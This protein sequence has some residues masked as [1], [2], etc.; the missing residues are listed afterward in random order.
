MV[1]S[2]DEFSTRQVSDKRLQDALQILAKRASI[3]VT[4]DHLFAAT[5]C[6]GDSKLLTLLETGLRQGSTK[7]DLRKHAESILIER[8]SPEAVELRRSDF[9]ASSLSLLDEFSKSVESSDGALDALGLELLCSLLVSKADDEMRSS[10]DMLDFDRATEKLQEKV[11]RVLHRRSARH[12]LLV[13]PRGV[14]KST[15]VATNTR[16]TYGELTQVL[17]T[18]AT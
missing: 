16:E 14:A 4:P 7:D 5:V 6:F 9:S 12:V 3:P 2:N 1:F 18:I 8:R 15:V 17:G 13:G 10:W 11:A